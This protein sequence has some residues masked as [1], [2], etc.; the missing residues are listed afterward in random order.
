[1]CSPRIFFHSH[2][3]PSWR[4][5]PP[6]SPSSRAL[7]WRRRRPSAPSSSLVPRPPMAAAAGPPPNP[8]SSHALPWRQRPALHPLLLPPPAPSRTSRRRT[9]G[10]GRGRCGQHGRCAHR[11][12]RSSPTTPRRAVLRDAA[13]FSL[14]GGLSDLTRY[15]CAI[16]SLPEPA[17]IGKGIPAV[18]DLVI[19][20]LQFKVFFWMFL[21]LQS[22]WTFTSVGIDLGCRSSHMGNESHMGKALLQRNWI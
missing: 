19:L 1:M 6:H 15:L 12:R 13:P 17:S 18:Q 14:A 9:A 5:P 2:L 21:H 20:P 8:P 10:I 7:P 11:P 22:L 16:P 3:P 4:R